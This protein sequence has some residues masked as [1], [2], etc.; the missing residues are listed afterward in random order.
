MC[1]VAGTAGSCGV[2]EGWVV[3][4]T[5][6]VGFCGGLFPTQLIIALNV[7]LKHG[8]V[9]SRYGDPTICSSVGGSGIRSRDA[10]NCRGGMT[11]CYS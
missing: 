8:C 7:S 9:Q 10:S 2:T 5:R 11:A 4:G 1:F 3:P 6:V